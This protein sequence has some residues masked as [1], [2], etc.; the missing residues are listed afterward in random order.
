MLIFRAHIDSGKIENIAQKYRLYTKSL[1]LQNQVVLLKQ[2]FDLKK[3]MV[4]TRG[5]IIIKEK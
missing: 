3:R 5:T 4:L 1:Y 2:M